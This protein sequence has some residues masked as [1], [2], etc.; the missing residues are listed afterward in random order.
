MAAEFQVDP[1]RSAITV[2]GSLA[3]FAVREQAPG[4]LTSRLEG[5]VDAEVSETTLT[6]LEGPLVRV[7]DNGSWEPKAG[8]ETGS[9]P[10]C[11]GGKVSAIIASA[12]AAGRDMEFTLASAA[13]ELTGGTFDGRGVVFAFPPGG[14][15]AFDYR[16]SGLGATAARMPLEGMSTNASALPGTLVTE[17]NVQTLRIS[18]DATYV[19]GLLAEGDTEVRIEGALV[20]TRTLGGSPVTFGSW[21][22]GFFPGETDEAIIGPE[23]NPDLDPWL[24]FV[25]FALGLNPVEP[26]PDFVPLQA[27]RADGSPGAWLVGYDRPQGLGGVGYQLSSGTS[28]TG[29]APLATVPEIVDLGDGWERVSVSLEPPAG[30][31]PAAFVLLSVHPE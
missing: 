24:N 8:G 29:W 21:I 15:A 26:E 10:A 9:D 27:H 1:E 11:F 22:E 7:Q 4:S 13:L 16:V 23:A 19:F 20:A 31:D 30:E 28:L 12:V 5:T 17:G 14:R 2:S 25:E 6:F 3:T 18:L